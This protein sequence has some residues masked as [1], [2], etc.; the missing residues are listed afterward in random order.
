MKRIFDFLKSRNRRLPRTPKK[1][2]LLL[3]SRAPF[4]LKSPKVG[5]TM[6]QMWRRPTFLLPYCHLYNSEFA[7]SPDPKVGGSIP[8]AGSTDS[9]DFL[10]IPL[11]V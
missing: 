10:P 2:K 8:L 1:A 6:A 4:V 11:L 3:T 9:I 7:R 5:K